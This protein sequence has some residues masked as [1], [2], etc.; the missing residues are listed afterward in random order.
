MKRYGP[1]HVFGSGLLIGDPG[2]KHLRVTPRAL[3]YVDGG[4]ESEW[5]PWEDTD[6]VVLKLQTTR[7]RFPGMLSGLA[8]AIFVAVTAES[9]DFGPED[10]EVVVRRGDT[11]TRYPLSRHHVGGY[12]AKGV[13]ATQRMLDRLVADA[14]SRAL[15]AHPDA[16]LDLVV[17]TARRE[18][19]PAR[20]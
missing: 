12:W 20:G 5:F 7:F 16:L 10:G 6:E 1:L 15:A 4:A 8:T 18:G 11:S 19:R 17:R 9:P 14:P 13:D 3:V 2:R